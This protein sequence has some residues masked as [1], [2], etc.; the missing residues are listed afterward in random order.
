MNIFQAQNLKQFFMI[1]LAWLSGL[2]FLHAQ[3]IPDNIFHYSTMEALR[4]AAYTGDITISKL[5]KKGDFGLGTFNQLDGELIAL[6]GKFYRIAANG[7]V[8]LANLESK[9]PFSSLTHFVK[10]QSIIL[11]NIKDFDALQQAILKV[12][13]S[14]NHF[15][16]IRINTTFDTIVTGGAIKVKED[17]TRGIATFMKTRPLY[18]ATKSSGTIIGFYCPPYVGGIDLSPFHFHYL[19][20]DKKYGGHLVS[21]NFAKAN[22]ITV[23]L[24]VKEQYEIQLPAHTNDGYKKLWK[25]SRG[26]SSY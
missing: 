26:Q 11:K 19:S 6:D 18:H 10:D 8:E 22:T 21:G 9:V 16:A 23:E 3:I 24:D 7:K 12:L 1:L 13:P 2:S 20:G 5:Q 25:T 15:Y 4:N 17:E 14:P